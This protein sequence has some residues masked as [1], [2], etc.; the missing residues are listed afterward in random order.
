MKGDERHIYMNCRMSYF[1]EWDIKVWEGDK[2]FEPLSKYWE[3]SREF[4]LLRRNE[5][6]FENRNR[7]EIMFR[8]ER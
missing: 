2:E 8:K 3:G 7:K 4:E 6:R 1:W 5:L